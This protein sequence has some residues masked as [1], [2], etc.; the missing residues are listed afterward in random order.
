LAKKT[1]K[2]RVR[3][4]EE[5]HANK[6]SQNS[7]TAHLDPTNAPPS[8]YHNYTDRSEISFGSLMNSISIKTTEKSKKNQEIPLLSTL[9][10][11][12]AR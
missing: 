12:K 3:P 6:R 1:S 9:L 11:L 10:N 2:F 5:P 7:L 4:N 8:R